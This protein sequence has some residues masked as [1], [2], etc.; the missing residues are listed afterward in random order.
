[1]TPIRVQTEKAVFTSVVQPQIADRLYWSSALYLAKEGEDVALYR[2]ASACEGPVCLCRAPGIDPQS[3]AV[4][5]EGLSVVLSIERGGDK[6]LHLLLLGEESTI[7]LTEGPGDD[8]S[9]AF[10]PD[11]SEIAFLSDRAGHSKLY[12]ISLVTRHDLERSYRPLPTWE[13]VYGVTVGAPVPVLPGA[14]EE[15]AL[16]FGPLGLAFVSNLAGTWDLWLLEGA[17]RTS[18]RRVISGVDPSSPIAW[19]GDRIFIVKD[20]TPGLLSLDARHFQPIESE[21]SEW[22]LLPGAPT[23]LGRDEGLWRVNLPEP[24]QPHLAY[25]RGGDAAGDETAELWLATMDGRTWQA[26]D[27]VVPGEIA[28]S[29]SGEQMAYL[30]RL[31]RTAPLPSPEGGYV[32]DWCELLVADGAGMNVQTILRFNPYLPP[33][34]PD[35]LAWGLDGE[36]IYFTVAGSVTHDEIWSVRPDGT[37]LRGVTWG[38]D[39]RLLPRD[40]IGGITRG[41]YPFIF[42]E[43]AGEKEYFDD[44]TILGAVVFS[45]SGDWALGA[46]GNELVLLNWLTR[47][48]KEIQLD[49]RSPPV[50][51]RNLT[52]TWAP[53]D[54]AIALGFSDDQGG[55]IYVYD[56]ETGAM[57][58]LETGWSAS[59]S[60]S[61]SSDGRSIAL[62]GAEGDTGALLVHDLGTGVSTTVI[63]VDARLSAPVWRVCRREQ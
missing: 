41:L 17:G 27:R 36:R 2:A 38:W 14:S 34:M 4:G 47:S 30:R 7:P 51:H 32:A 50:Q 16:A 45:P 1:M 19:I 22:W 42:D 6:K 53:D 21:I 33:W 49:V 29:P 8:R 44:D 48:K 58:R 46:I 40:R 23:F 55:E 56:M 37:G 12:T 25:F 61:W 54:S 20:G 59:R 62:V 26:A 13:E 52:V 24:P 60:P 11:K 31:P 9:P 28:W 15:S 35:E 63:A 5:W 3:L 39:Y 18:L 10:S 43:Q 57:R